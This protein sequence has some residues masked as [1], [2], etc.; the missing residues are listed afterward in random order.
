MKDMGLVISYTSIIRFVKILS[1]LVA[2]VLMTMIFMISSENNFGNPVEVETR[3]LDFSS[4]FQI[5][6]AQLAGLDLDGNRF[7]FRASKINPINNDLPI[8][9][10]N[11]IL[12]SITFTSEMLIQIQAEKA[13]IH[14]KNNLI[15]LEGELQLENENF[16][17]TG[18]S[19]TINFEKN[20]LHSNKA[21][22]IFLPNT[23][24]QAGKLKALKSDSNNLHF[25]FFLENGVKFKYFL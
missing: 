25:K 2:L 15:N 7:N 23:E 19:I 18:T 16:R 20:A 22:K 3:D 24:I 8:I 21:I 1:T 11:D 13:N 6:G 10:V 12:G 9:S 14:T 17:L 5:D 4:G